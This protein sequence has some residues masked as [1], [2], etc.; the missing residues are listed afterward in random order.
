M[1]ITFRDNG[2][3]L[4]YDTLLR[5]WIGQSES[6][7]LRA[8]QL[9]AQSERLGIH[10]RRPYFWKKIQETFPEGPLFFSYWDDVIPFWLKPELRLAL[11]PRGI[12][13]IWMNTWG[14]RSQ[15]VINPLAWRK[16]SFLNDENLVLGIL[17]E[18][19]AE[20]LEQLPQNIKPRSKIFWMPDFT[21]VSL[22]QEDDPLVNDVLQFADG[23]KILLCVG[24]MNGFK[25]LELLAEV[26]QRLSPQKWV[27]AIL[28]EVHDEKGLARLEE[29]SPKNMFLRKGRLSSE[30]VFNLILKHADLIWG[31]Y[32]NWEGSSNIQVKAG[33]LKVPI[34]CLDGYLMAERNQRYHLGITGNEKEILDWAS[35]DF[36]VLEDWKNSSTQHQ[37]E[38]NF[39]SESARQRFLQ[40]YRELKSL[41]IEKDKINWCSKQRA[42]V[43]YLM[44]LSYQKFKTLLKPFKNKS[45]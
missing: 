8:R 1:I 18:G 27:V 33:L 26:A 41:E 21:D 39:G 2:H 43:Y 24:V 6:T 25:N 28:G 37:F 4:S 23:R 7:I 31:A 38:K 20:A 29:L 15:G 16:Y 32:R 22:A 42:R 19:V 3:H 40:I 35:R 10:F 30:G 17:D 14:F 44:S 12:G 36:R 5:E 9:L 13:S 34:L 45:S 11:C